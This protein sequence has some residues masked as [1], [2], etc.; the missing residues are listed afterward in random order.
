[1]PKSKGTVASIDLGTTKICVCIGRLEGSAIRILGTGWQPSAGLR[2]GVVAN[3]SET[4]GSVKACL[5]QAESEAKTVVESAYVSVGGTFVRGLNISGEV[6]VRGKGNCVFSDDVRRAV[7][8]AEPREMPEGYEILHKL[9]QDFSLDG[10]GGIEE[11]IGMTGNHLAVKVHVV[12]N[13][14]AVIQNVANTINQAN[15][16]VDGVV[17]QQLASAEAVLT[18]DEKELGT[19]L[20]DIGGGTTD[21]SVYNRGS[22]WHSEVLPMGGALITK[23][24]AIGL[25]AP[26]QDA[27]EIKTTLGSVFPTEVPDEEIVEIREMGSDRHRVI[28]RRLVCQIIEARSVEILKAIGKILEK[29]KVRP[30]LISGIVLT[31]G[32]SLMHGLPEKAQEIL[33]F[34]VRLGYPINFKTKNEQILNP[35]YATALGLVRYAKEIQQEPTERP[36]QSGMKKIRAWLMGKI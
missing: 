1:M 7:A 13:A 26:L 3:L 14:S 31:G 10:H 15:V 17:M 19:V 33:G 28:S 34:D 9:T 24:L 6:E 21:I 18:E 27:E 5:E 2:K 22:I 8:E 4:A 35:T 36:A 30:Q 23:D 32:G 12:L 20:V 11:P 16:V 25:R 29:A